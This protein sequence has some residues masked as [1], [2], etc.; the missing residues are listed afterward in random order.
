MK[1]TNPLIPNDKDNLGRMGDPYVLR[2][3]GYYYHCYMLEDGVYL[4][5]S[6][7]LEDIGKDKPICVYKNDG[8]PKTWYAPELHII[9]GDCYIYGA[10]SVCYKNDREWHSVCVLHKKGDDPIGEYELLG[11]IDGIKGD[12]SLDATV[13]Y[14]NGKR[15]LV[16]VSNYIYIA[17]LETPTKIGDK[18]AAIIKAEYDW[19]KVMQAITEGPAVLQHEGETYIAYSSSDCRSDGYCI[20]YIKYLGGDPI[21]ENSWKKIGRPMLSSGN[22]VFG[23][24]HCSFTKVL[25]NGKDEDFIVYHATNASGAG[26]KGRTVWAQKVDWS[27][28]GPVFG[29]PKPECEY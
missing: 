10:P 4:T 16:Y 19:E 3:N 13:L 26:T 23:T 14:L 17:E 29:E 18:R 6:K 7:N 11:E 5:K 28:E 24:G 25:L 2:H 27:D 15:Y 9:D 12:W 20:S 22:G 8:Y 21:D 1:Y